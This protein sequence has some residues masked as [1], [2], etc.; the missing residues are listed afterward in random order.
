MHGVMARWGK[1]K[2]RIPSSRHC[3]S[4]LHVVHQSEDADESESNEEHALE[5]GHIHGLAAALQLLVKSSHLLVFALA[6]LMHTSDR[7]GL[8]F[9]TLNYRDTKEV[10]VRAMQIGMTKQTPVT[11]RLMTYASSE[12]SQLPSSASGTT[13]CDR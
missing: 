8:I 9:L 11:V 2:K 4:R 10:G 5:L 3:E 13:P 7:R 12:G 1:H 6:V